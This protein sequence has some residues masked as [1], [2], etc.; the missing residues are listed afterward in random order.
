LT[1]E[2]DVHKVVCF[3]KLKYKRFRSNRLIFVLIGV[4][5]FAFLLFLLPQFE[6]LRNHLGLPGFDKLLDRFRQ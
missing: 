2:A 5:I 4:L 6:G 3:S 1:R